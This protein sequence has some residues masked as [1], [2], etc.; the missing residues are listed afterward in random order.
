MEKS[1]QVPRLGGN[2]NK[3]AFHWTAGIESCDSSVFFFSGPEQALNWMLRD[4]LGTATGERHAPSILK[5]WLM[6]FALLNAPLI[7]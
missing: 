4:T 5:C 2:N 7:L 3:R 1:E 6:V